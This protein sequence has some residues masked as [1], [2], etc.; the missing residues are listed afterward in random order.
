MVLVVLLVEAIPQYLA[1]IRTPTSVS[2]AESETATQ[3]LGR[4]A[5]FFA[6]VFICLL[7]TFLTRLAIYGGSFETGYIP[8][9]DW[10]W[11]SP[12]FFSVLFSSNHGLLS[13]TPLL[14]LAIVGIFIFWRRV[15]GVGTAFAAAFLAF[16]LF[17]CCYPDWAGISSYGNRFFVSLTILFVLGL[18]IFLE[19][20]AKLFQN[21][22]LAL[23]VASAVLTLFLAWNV[24]FIYQW[25]EHLIPLRGPISFAEMA[26]NQFFVVPRQIT[27]RLETYLFRRKSMMD[28]IEKRD[29]EQLKNQ[30]AE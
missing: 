14:G 16:Y 10:L 11:R 28:Q 22:K 21:R 5:L 7:P 15:P 26:H 6:V 3:L 23:A 8:L 17:I 24:E 9:K 2:N 25:G 12:V 27:R 20:A 30:N 18:G 29:I 19:T 13:W 4:H 1:S